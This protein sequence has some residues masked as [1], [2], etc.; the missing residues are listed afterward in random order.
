VEAFHLPPPVGRVEESQLAPLPA[1]SKEW[2]D[3]DSKITGDVYPRLVR[4]LNSGHELLDLAVR[5]PD[6]LARIV[7]RDTKGRILWESA[8]QTER[9]GA[10]LICPLVRL[11][12]EDWAGG[13]D[14]TSLEGRIA[15]LKHPD[16]IVRRLAS[17]ELRSFPKT[18]T[19]ILAA[20]QALG[21]TDPNVRHNALLALG[22]IGMKAELIVSE[23]GHVLRSDPDEWNNLVAASLL[24]CG[25]P[26]SAEA[27]RLVYIDKTVTNRQITAAYALGGH[28]DS[29]DPRVH[30]AIRD[31]FHNPNSKVRD[32]ICLGLKHAGT[33][34]G[35]YVPDLIAALEDP[36]DQVK[37]DAAKA[38]KF[39]GDSAAIS[40]LVKVAQSES[41][42]AGIVLVSVGEL[43][44]EDLRIARLLVATLISVKGKSARASNVAAIGRHRGKKGLEIV[45]P[46]LVGILLNDEE[47][48]IVRFC[49]RDALHRMGPLAKAAASALLERIQ[50]NK[51]ADSGLKLFSLLEEIDPAAAVRLRGK[52]T[53][54]AAAGIIPT[55]PPPPPK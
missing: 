37:L 24:Q 51:K 35:R 40:V 49:A 18:D 5:G 29:S 1:E 47:D 39:I 13:M 54:P 8:Y 48:Q 55:T 25:G 19:V 44:K 22:G 36:E 6:D 15:L 31:A 9:V 38:L 11:G 14:R 28:P 10:Y 2:I 32:H 27:A 52:E 53:L 26:K 34:A 46:I 20:A 21:D 42:P 50:A 17:Q 45:V 4:R 30:E 23:L 41:P 33:K 43:G 7:E 3:I 16:R 12:F